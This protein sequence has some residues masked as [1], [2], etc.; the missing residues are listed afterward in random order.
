MNIQ[1]A[2]K[3]STETKRAFTRTQ[4]DNYIALVPTNNPYMLVMVIN[5]NNKSRLPGRG[6]QPTADD[7]MSNDWY[8]TDINYQ[9]LI[10]EI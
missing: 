5:V 4:I 9:N 8:I 7:L 10:T 1:E 3:K 2:V 6:W